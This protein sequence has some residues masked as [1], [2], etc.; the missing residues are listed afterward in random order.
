MS[1]GG[2]EFHVDGELVVG[3]LLES[4]LLQGVRC[5]GE[6]LTHEHLRVSVQ[7][8]CHDVQETLGLR[9][10][11]EAFF[12]G[13]EGRARGQQEGGAC[14]GEGGWQGAACRAEKGGE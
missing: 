3:L 6:Q 2:E 5:V 11:L 10:E 12:V 13:G 14:G 4:L 8:F 1:L 7:R 9:L